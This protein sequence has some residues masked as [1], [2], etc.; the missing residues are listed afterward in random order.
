MSIFSGRDTILISQY[1]SKQMPE[2]LY[3]TRCA[4]SYPDPTPYLSSYQVHGPW[5]FF[6]PRPQVFVP[7]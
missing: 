5:I 2:V 1:L 7:F 4:Y 3:G 6:V